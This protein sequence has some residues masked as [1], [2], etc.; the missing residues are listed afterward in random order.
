MALGFARFPLGFCFRR[1]SLH[2]FHPTSSTFSSHLS[3]NLL[4]AIV[5]AFLDTISL[6]LALSTSG[7]T[8]LNSNKI[9]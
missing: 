9:E 5:L 6:S 1:H 2:L 7:L 3:Q 8:F 4:L